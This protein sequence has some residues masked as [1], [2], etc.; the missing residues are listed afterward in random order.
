MNKEQ[1]LNEWSIV[2]PKVLDGLK[3]L[4]HDIPITGYT[5]QD[6]AREMTRRRRNAGI[7]Q[8]G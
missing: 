8:K 2:C 7:K 1:F 3:K 5:A 6:A 4:G